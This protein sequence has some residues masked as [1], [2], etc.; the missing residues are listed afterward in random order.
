MIVQFAVLFLFLALGEFVVYL[1]DIP[2]PASIIGMILL[3]TALKMNIIKERWVTDLAD[4]FVK[5][6]GFFFVPAGVGVMACLGLISQQWLPIVVA[7]VISTFIIIASTG[8]IH[9]LTR[10]VLKSAKANKD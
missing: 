5:N 10:R 4:F 8:W 7:T 1:T 2:I 6:L 9:Q 3:A